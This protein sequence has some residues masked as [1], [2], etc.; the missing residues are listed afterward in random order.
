[1]GKQYAKNPEQTDI[2]VIHCRLCFAHDDFASTKSAMTQLIYKIAPRSLWQTA[3]SKG[4]FDGAPIDHA[5]GYIHFSTAQQAR[6]TADKHFAGQDD[7]LLVAVRADKLGQA[8]KYEVSRGGALFPHLYAVLPLDAVEWVK[9]L[10]L[11]S[12]GRHAFPELAA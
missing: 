1:M 7:L 12:D 6:E 3:E 2:S 8:L 10:P 5:D 11:G 9:P 4:V